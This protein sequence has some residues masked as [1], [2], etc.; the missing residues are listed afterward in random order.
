MSRRYK[1]NGFGSGRL[2]MGT[3][4]ND[5]FGTYTRYTYNGCDECIVIS[6]DDKILVLNGK[7]EYSTRE[8]MICFKKI[9]RLKNKNEMLN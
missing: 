2:S 7:D 9:W 4:K 5:E 1:D 6:V 3:F 8:I